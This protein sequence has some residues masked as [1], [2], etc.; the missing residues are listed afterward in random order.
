MKSG[1]HWGGGTSLL[2]LALLVPALTPPPAAA[3]SAAEVFVGGSGVLF[4]DGDSVSD[5]FVITDTG[6][7]YRVVNQRLWGPADDDPPECVLVATRPP[8]IDCAKSGIASITVNGDPTICS[9]DNPNGCPPGTGDEITF[10]TSGFGAITSLRINGGLGSDVING[11]P[12]ADM[13]YGETGN[14][15]LAGGA[16]PDVFSGGSGDNTV[17]YA[18]HADAVTADIDQSSDDGNLLDG[19]EGVR[20]RIGLDVQNLTGTAGPDLLL[21]S[22]GTNRLQGLGGDDRLYGQGAPDRLGGGAGSDVLNGGADADQADGGDGADRLA[23]NSGDDLLSG[24]PGSDL[25]LGGLGIDQ[26]FGRG[27]DDVLDARDGGADDMID[28]G[29]GALDQALLDAGVDPAPLGC[30]T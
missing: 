29:G 2:V 6:D 8:T 20:D 7:S 16:G 3:W 9:F 24:G 13:I 11:S 17:S 10:G 21:G 1:F 5:R 15:V 19:P 28:C 18:D 30:E 25:L 26:L 23:G 22:S 4:V 12:V 27:G 14:D